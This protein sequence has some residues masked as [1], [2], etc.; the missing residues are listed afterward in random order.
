MYVDFAYYR[1]IYGGTVMTEASFPAAEREAENYIRY[2]TYVN[3]DIFAD[4]VQADAVK[5]AVCTAA[6]VGYAAKVEQEHGGN[7]KSE[8]KDGFSVS[9]IV[10]RRDGESADEYTKRCMYQAVRPVLLPTGWLSRRGKAGCTHDHKCK[11]GDCI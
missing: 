7:L 3:G 5:N 10:S 6:D 9:F 8:S 11:S 1:D 2:L 4:T